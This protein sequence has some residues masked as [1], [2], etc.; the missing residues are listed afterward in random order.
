MQVAGMNDLRVE[1]TVIQE[2]AS[3]Q[4]CVRLLDYEL[5]AEKKPFA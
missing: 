5:A 4:R 3:H 1:A 2:Q